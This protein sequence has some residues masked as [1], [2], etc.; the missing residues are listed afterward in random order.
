MLGVIGGMGPLASSLF[1][2]M[3][4]D[5]TDAG[6]DQDNLNMIIY[7]DSGMPDRTGAIL[8]GDDAKVAEV[9]RACAQVFQLQGGRDASKA[10]TAM[11]RYRSLKDEYE[12]VNAETM[13]QIRTF[14]HQRPERFDVHVK[15]AMQAWDNFLQT[16]VFGS[17]TALLMDQP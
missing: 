14:L 15:A 9:D 3:I 5:K 17:P 2:D 13:Y 8:S 6:C 12:K 11:T 10:Q 7:S 4:I 1:Y 16:L